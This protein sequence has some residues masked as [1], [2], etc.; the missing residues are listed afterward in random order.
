MKKLLVILMTA[1]L[2]MAPLVS[3]AKNKVKKVELTSKN[4]V[5]L[6]G[7]ITYSSV[8]KVQQQLLFLSALNSKNS[9]LY[10]F[11]DTP[12]GDVSAGMELINTARTIPQE[13]VTIT[14]FAA[15]MGYI[16]VQHLGSRYI[17]SNGI[18]MSHR[19]TVGLSGQIPGELNTRMN[20]IGSMI[21]G[22]EEDISKRVG[23]SHKDYAKLIK[24][25]YWVYGKN[26]VK[27]K[28]ADAVVTVSCGKSLI[29]LYTKT[30][31]TLFGPVFLR[32]SKCPLISSPLGI[33]FKRTNTSGLSIKEKLAF[34]NYIKTAFTDKRL[35]VEKYIS[36]NKTLEYLK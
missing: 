22:I 21:K 1:V 10:L 31:G 2:F 35:F 11:L 25:E 13:V 9:V 32:M 23:M 26:A 19:A 14:K 28:Q 20:F 5:V 7:P 30:V 36:P 15:S 34:R 17:L 4:M 12:G 16:T 3:K 6:R 29:G 18:L 24:D 33:S 8:A 27:N